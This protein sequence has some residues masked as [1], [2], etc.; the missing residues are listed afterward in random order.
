MFKAREYKFK[1]LEHKFQ[2]LKHN[3]PNVLGTFC[4]KRKKVIACF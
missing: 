4:F 3:F 2:G 1:G